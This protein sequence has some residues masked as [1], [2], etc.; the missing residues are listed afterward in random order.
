MCFIHN[1]PDLIFFFS[2][3]FRTWPL[4]LTPARQ[5][6]DHNSSA[7]PADH[8][9]GALQAFTLVDEHEKQLSGVCVND[10]GKTGG[11]GGGGLVGQCQ[12]VGILFF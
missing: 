10:Y 9:T 2:F 12:K 4:N 1:S 11:G 7:F 5:R 3:C 6:L 8:I